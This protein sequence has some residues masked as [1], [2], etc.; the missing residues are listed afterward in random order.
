MAL[1]FNFKPVATLKAKSATSTDMF[2]FAGVT[3]ATTTPLNAAT[4][5]NKILAIVGKQCAADENM[6]R[7]IVEESVD[8]E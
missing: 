7:T 5:A 6:T 8:D 2:T 1:A 4:Q 3:T